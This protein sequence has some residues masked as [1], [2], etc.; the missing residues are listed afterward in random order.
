[1]CHSDTDLPVLVPFLYVTLKR[2]FKAY[3]TIRNDL[4]AVKAM[5]DFHASIGRN[6]DELLISGQFEP[7]I[8]LLE[9]FLAW[10][11]TCRTATN[12]IGRVAPG[13]RDINPNTRDSYLRSLRLFFSWCAQRYWDDGECQ[14]SL[15]RTFH[16]VASMITMRFDGFLLA[17]A[18][19]QIQYRSLSE[20]EIDLLRIACLPNSPCNPFR[21]QN[22]LR[23]WLMFE[24]L[25]ETGVRLGELLLLTTTDVA[26][27]SNRCYLTITNHDNAGND[28]RATRPSIK[29]LHSHRTISISRQLY[30]NL[31]FYIRSARRPIR[32]GRA[33]KLGHRFLWVS[34]R[35]LPLAVNTASS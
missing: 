32:N 21:Q 11:S 27:G 23:N 6:L 14:S 7:I 29:T 3:N 4:L 31:Q 13:N 35:G 25:Q 5:Y 1:M 12:M 15:T 20:A 30:D 18:A 34:E 28:T 8:G 17:P 16:D 9:R 2:Q 24:V 26:M 22:R 33:I 10:L 19:R